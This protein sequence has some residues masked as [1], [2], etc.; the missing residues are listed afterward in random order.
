MS[1]LAEAAVG[2]TVVV[3]ALCL[4]FAGAGRER[5]ALLDAALLVVAA[6]ALAVTAVGVVGLARGHRPAEL[7]THVGY[8]V[9]TPMILPIAAGSM[10]PDRGQWSST[11]CAVGCLVVAVMLVRVVATSRG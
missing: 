10:A 8:L 5:P 11:A 2:Y 1:A 4:G 6:G 3:M 7:A 9:A